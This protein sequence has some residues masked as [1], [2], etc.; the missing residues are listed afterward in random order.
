MGT[1]AGLAILLADGNGRGGGD[2][3]ED[4]VSG[5]IGRWAGDRIVIAGDYADSGRFVTKSMVKGL[6]DNDGHPITP[7]KINVNNLTD[8]SHFKDISF[9][10]IFALMAEDYVRKE[11][12]KNPSSFGRDPNIIK[13]FNA[14]HE[15]LAKD[16]KGMVL[17]VGQ[18]KSPEGKSILE[19][20]LKVPK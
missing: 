18:L 20:L 9:D 3:S 7:D 8:T 12:I 4:P 6:A 13:D 2:I 19:K 14:I 5:I 16:Q 1:M 11:Y 15:Q 17:L 10:V